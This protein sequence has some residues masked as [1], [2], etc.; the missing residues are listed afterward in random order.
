MNFMELAAS[1]YSVRKYRP[2]PIA[3]EAM[4]AILARGQGEEFINKTA[5]LLEQIK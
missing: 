1:R 4:A 3:D 2:E 5:E